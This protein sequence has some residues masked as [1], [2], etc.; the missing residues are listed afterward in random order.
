VLTDII[1]AATAP[2]IIVVIVNPITSSAKVMPAY[3]LFIRTTRTALGVFCLVG[4]TFL[5]A[6]DLGLVGQTFLSASDLGLVGQTFLSASD[7]G[8][9]TSDFGSM[10]TSSRGRQECLPHRCES[11]R[12]ISEFVTITAPP[13]LG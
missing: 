5:S 12:L 3:R 8:T 4:H 10:S 7:V 1:N 2:E 13:P 6:S 9:P 11:D